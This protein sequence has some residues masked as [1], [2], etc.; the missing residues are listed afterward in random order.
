METITG[1]TVVTEARKWVG[2]KFVHTGRQVGVGVDCVGLIICVFSSAAGLAYDNR[3][4]SRLMPD[5]LV[6]AELEQWLMPVADGEEWAAGDV[7]LFKVGGVEQHVAF[8]TGEGTIVHAYQSA[9]CVAEHELTDSWR[10][11]VTGVFRWA[12]RRDTWPL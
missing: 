3:N 8:W 12:G 1:Q 7:L 11:R 2:T 9:K 6:R 4:Y 10:Y 5:G